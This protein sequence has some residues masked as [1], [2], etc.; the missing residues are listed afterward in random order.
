MQHPLGFDQNKP[1]NMAFISLDISSVVIENMKNK[2]PIPQTWPHIPLYACSHGCWHCT[3]S[4]L[5]I[6]MELIFML[7]V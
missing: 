1:I 7:S 6:K 5:F 2:G 4:S 3:F